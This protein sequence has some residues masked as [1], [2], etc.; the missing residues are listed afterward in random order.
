MV[1]AAHMR[2]THEIELKCPWCEQADVVQLVLNLTSHLP[3][4][5]DK[6]LSTQ[7]SLRP[8][9][10]IAG[11]TTLARHDCPGPVLVL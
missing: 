5:V 1:D 8:G 10:G 11:G 6:K 2:A 4:G 3:S 7:W 9:M